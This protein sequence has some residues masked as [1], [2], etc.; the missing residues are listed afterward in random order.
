[1][2]IIAASGLTA[3]RAHA[4]DAGKAVKH[5]LAKPYA[6]ETLLAALEGVLGETSRVRSA[7]G[8]LRGQPRLGPVKKEKLPATS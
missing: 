5:F 1:V 7:P 8:R 4:L 2:R 6:A 3:N